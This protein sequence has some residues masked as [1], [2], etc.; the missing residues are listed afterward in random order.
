[1]SGGSAG[2]GRTRLTAARFTT[3]AA[4][5]ALLVGLLPGLALAADTPPPGAAAGWSAQTKTK[6]GGTGTPDR[7]PAA[8][9]AKTIGSG[10][11]T[12]KDRAWTTSGDAQG[13]H[14]L[15]ADAKDGYAW[16][17]AATLYEPGFDADAWIGNACLT[18]SGKRA[19]VAY[20]PRTFTNKPEL[21]AR[22]AFTAVV[23]LTTGKVTK[24]AST[25]SL[26]YFSPGCGTGEKAVLTQLTHDGEKQNATRLISVDTATGKSSAPLRLDGQVTSAVPTDQGIVAAHGTRLVRIGTDGRETEIARTASIPF[27][28]R[29]DRSGGVTYIERLPQASGAKSAGAKSAGTQATSATADE[30]VA[31]RVDARQIRQGKAAPATLA[32]GPLVGWDLSSAAD[33]TVYVTGKAATQGTLPEAVKNPG[34]LAKDDR[35]STLGD[36]AVG[37]SWAPGSDA[38][39]ASQETADEPRSVRTRLSVLDTGAK[40]TLETEPGAEPVAPQQVAAGGETSP[41]LR[42]APA[43]SA[44]ASGAKAGSA[45]T[46]AGA[47]ASAATTSAL[48][49]AAASP[50]D[51]V[52]AERMCA[53]PRGDVKKQALQ[54]T[55]RQA[56]WAVDQAV[57]DGLYMWA[58]RPANWNNTGMSPYSPQV[59]FPLPV[60]EGDPNGVVDRADEYHIPAQIL[61]GV[62]A[63]ES[64]MWQAARTVVPGVSGNPLIGNYYGIA[65]SA[66]GNQADPWAVNWA[67]ADCGYGITQVTDGMRVSDTQLSLKQKEAAALDY[68]ANIAYG[69]QILASK[70]NETRIAGMTVNGGKPK[71]IENWFFALWAY[72]SGFHPQSAAGSN[73]GKWGVGW[74]NN[75]ANPLWKENRLPFLESSSGGDD[76]SHAARPQEWPYQEKVI[77]WAARPISALF[78][79]GDMQAGYR[80]AW[81]NNNPA[82]TRAKPPNMLFCT[83]SNDCDQSKI[84]DGASNKTGMGPCTLPGDPDESNPLYLKCWWHEAV[85]WKNCEAAAECGNPVHRF[86]NSDYPEQP[87]E[88]SSYP[89]RCSSGLPSGTFIVDDVANGVTPMG[90][91]GHTCGVSNS[92]GSFGFT[93]TDSNGTYPGK[94]DLHQIGAGYGDHFWF[95]HT[96]KASDT[97]GARLKTTGTWTLGRTLDQWVRVM[98]H[99]PDHGAHTQQAKY[100]IDTGSGSFTRSRTL[101]QEYKANTWVSLG[102]YKVSGT[103]RVRL[104]STT[105]DGTG[106]ADVAWDAVG[107][108]PLAAK[109]K[110]IVAVLGDSFTSGEGAGSYSVES[111]KD[112]GT[113]EWN[114]CR[115]SSNAWARKLVLPGT[116][117]SLGAIADTRGSAAE[118]GFVACSGAM[119]KNVAY[120]PSGNSPQNHGEGQFGEVRQVDSGVLSADT[121]LVML[122]LGGNDEGGFATAMQEC[123]SLSDCSKDSG[124]LPKYK[125]IV[126]RMIADLRYVVDDIS[127]K[128]Q[129]AQI[130]LMGYPELLSRTVKCAGSLYYD[131]PEVNALAQLVNYADDQQKA[132][133]DGL[134]ATGMKIEYANPV[135]AFVGHSGCDDPEWINKFVLG[136]N[137]DGDFHLGDP[138]AVPASCLWGAMG[139]SCISRESFHPKSA[140]TTGYADVMRQRLSAIGYAGTP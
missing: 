53:V 140:G 80:A 89:P 32:R 2:R 68:S 69:A 138:A 18:R 6:P 14:V 93:F 3:A 133:A 129:N 78:K 47:K 21:M 139:G 28:L 48:A 92:A 49:A 42:V 118:L 67:K 20:A 83:A 128:A 52:E 58:N 4:T 76:Y 70:W 74:T 122:T 10:Y 135:G 40:V 113:S 59:L 136:P 95:T 62:T 79:P 126:D 101:G 111:N 81:W 109:P 25:A 132:M 51:P 137:G 16:K 37:T 11:R 116:T 73:G 65:Y 54:P 86:N 41:A 13:F 5:T 30:S 100:E 72:N 120:V 104:A 29:P 96:R 127:G 34:T 45:K 63:Q 1:M 134:R 9:R 114:A 94:I 115:R 26:A 31:R 61:L 56:E 108:Q 87:N 105:L 121:T 98:V 103:P 82:R 55:P 88:N 91:T 85:T 99:V 77:G 125:A 75:P 107:F 106:D 22:G 57:I 119:T 35:M 110:H 50:N 44:T 36:A 90:Q 12:S 46:A 84:V 24:L 102:V 123:G 131:M 33:G 15:V 97:D 8:D 39:L 43:T 130:M 7:V 64:N 71:Y 19:V 27:Q 38:P 60:L 117:E 23:D 112:H 124:F 66:S 17:T